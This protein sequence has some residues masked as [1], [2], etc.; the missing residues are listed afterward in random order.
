MS[1]MW[2]LLLTNGSGAQCM[3]I[4]SLMWNYLSRRFLC[5]SV[6]AISCMYITGM[7]IIYERR[8]S[9]NMM[10][11]LH[12][13]I[14]QFY[15]NS[16]NQCLCPDLWSHLCSYR[17][18]VSAVPVASIHGSILALAACMLLVPY[19]MPRYVRFWTYLSRTKI[20]RKEHRKWLVGTIHLHTPICLTHIRLIEY[21]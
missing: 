19:D 15:M 20:V 21:H 17:S 8:G 14:S 13:E 4:I 2:W 12:P 3:V 1:I 10:W 6:T 5:I 11:V 16:M 7:H 9:F 18:K